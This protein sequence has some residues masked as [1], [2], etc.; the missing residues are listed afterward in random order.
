MRVQSIIYLYEGLYPYCIAAD[1]GYNG[2]ASGNIIII[3]AH[4]SNMWIMCA[5]CSYALK[6]QGKSV[7]ML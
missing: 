6:L 3:S 7:I 5:Y 4:N 2:D 1:A